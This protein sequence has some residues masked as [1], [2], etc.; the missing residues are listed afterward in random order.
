[1][2]AVVTPGPNP[3][4]SPVHNYDFSIRANDRE[5]G[6][7]LRGGPTP[8]EELLCTPPQSSTALLMAAAEVQS[9]TDRE[10]KDVETVVKFTQEC[11][12]TV[13][14]RAQERQEAMDRLL[15]RLNSAAIEAI[16]REAKVTWPWMMDDEGEEEVEEKE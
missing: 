13:I 14:K 3:S 9:L 12:E 11:L 10:K 16:A 2:P 4:T 1:M 8:F 6:V 7:S 5:E 15:L